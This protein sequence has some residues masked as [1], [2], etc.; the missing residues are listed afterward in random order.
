MILAATG[1]ARRREAP[2]VYP[3][4]EVGARCI[5]P[6]Y[7]EGSSNTIHPSVVDMVAETGQPF[8]GYRWWM[9]DTPYPDNPPSGGRDDYENPSIFAT[10]SR[11]TWH[12]PAGVINPVVPAPANLSYWNADTELIWDVDRF[13]LYWISQAPDGNPRHWHMTS[14]DGVTWSTPVGD[15]YPVEPRLSP[16]I[17]RHEVSNTWYKLNFGATTAEPGIWTAPTATGPWT[18]QGLVTI[19]GSSSETH[20]K[21]HGDMIRYK[22]HWIGVYSKMPSPNECRA[23][24]ATDDTA[25]TWLASGPYSTGIDKSY[26]PTLIP[27]TEDGYLDVWSSTPSAN[28]FYYRVHESVWLDL[29]T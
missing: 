29:L 1:T 10:N 23:M 14:P 7:V 24:I 28:L 4:P 12:V 2:V 15:P 26:R 6:T 8:G 13:V 20:Y 22:G 25:M 9:A 5:V 16:A 21:R 17:A 3:L 18:S 27:S 19:T 11:V